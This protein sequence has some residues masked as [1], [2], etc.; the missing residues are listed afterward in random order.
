MQHLCKVKK[1]KKGI[2]MKNNEQKEKYILRSTRQHN[3]E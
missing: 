3:L 1:K 2:K